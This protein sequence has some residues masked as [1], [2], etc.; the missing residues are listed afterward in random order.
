MRRG[1][2]SVVPQGARLLPRKKERGG[3]SA[4]CSVSNGYATSSDAAIIAKL[5]RAIDYI[6]S[7]AGQVTPSVR[8]SQMGTNSFENRLARRTTVMLFDIPIA[9]GFPRE[10]RF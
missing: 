10:R 7:S 5:V 4:R 2:A 3:R 9:K 1:T 8:P 6:V